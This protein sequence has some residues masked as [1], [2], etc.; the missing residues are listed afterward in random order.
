M[1]A[2]FYY[3]RIQVN[4]LYLF[5]DSVLIGQIDFLCFLLFC[6]CVAGCALQ[7]FFLFAQ[8]R[9]EN[10]GHENKIIPSN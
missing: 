7:N 3:L 4:L 5:H 10:I 1:A 9:A 2:H 8:F 6:V